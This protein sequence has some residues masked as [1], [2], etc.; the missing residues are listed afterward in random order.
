MSE[1]TFTDLS[2]SFAAEQ[3]LHSVSLTVPAGSSAAIV[4]P[5]GCGK[6]TLLRCI[7]GFE[8]P[9]AGTITL[10]ERTLVGPGRTMVPAHARRVGY[11]AQDGALF[12][13]LTVGANIAFGLPR[14]DRTEARIAELMESVSLPAAWA[15]RRPD[16]L[17]GGQQQRV[18]LARALARRPHLM[19]LD[20]P[21]SALDVGLRAETRERVRTILRDAEIT[22]VLVTHDQ[23]EALDFGDLIAVMERGVL[24]DVGEPYQVY[25]T[26]LTRHGARFLGDTLELPGISDGIKVRCAVGTLTLARHTP[27]GPVLVVLRPEQVSVVASAHGTAHMGETVLQGSSRRAT[28]FTESGRPITIPLSRFAPPLSPDEPVHLVVVG[29]V[30]AFAV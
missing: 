12:P 20:E 8:T 14:R 23:Q 10:G 28:V 22:T 24:T 3:I 18:S 7:A 26:P 27:P 29:D 13:H 25:T 1:L 2:K 4:G 9:D 15:T 11:V 16:Q 19:L 30:V 17:S 21:F 6:T 5:S